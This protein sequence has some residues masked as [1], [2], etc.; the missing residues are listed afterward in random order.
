M[1]SSLALACLLALGSLPRVIAFDMTKNNNVRF[2]PL[3]PLVV[4]L[5]SIILSSA[6]CVRVLHISAHTFGIN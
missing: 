1:R 2:D 3:L 6:R 4:L 5:T